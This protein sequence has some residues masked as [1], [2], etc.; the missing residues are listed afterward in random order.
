MHKERGG[1]FGGYV[2]TI[3]DYSNDPGNYIFLLDVLHGYGDEHHS[4]R[5][6][7]R[8]DVDMPIFEILD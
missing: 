7:M 4:Q 2:K 6:L 5:L 8:T 3:L 1:M